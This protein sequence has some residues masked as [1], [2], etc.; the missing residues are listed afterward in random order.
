MF[1]E[2]LYASKDTGAIDTKAG[3]L[4]DW[5]E[6]RL[7]VYGKGRKE[8]WVA[9]SPSTAK[10]V[11]DYVQRERPESYYEELFL[12][13]SGE[14]LRVDSLE[15]LIDRR[16]RAAGIRHVSVHAMR[17]SFALSWCKNGGPL[18]ALQTILG[19]STPTMSLRYGRASSDVA[20]ELHR[21]Y[22]PI[23]RLNMRLRDGEKGS[24]KRPK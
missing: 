15:A 5:Q 8:R 7:K 4:D 6:K 9:L 16:A 24:K 17:H 22:S 13:K 12:N 20:M 21:Q 2:K 23:D 14:P 1:L 3:W 10:S 18:S 11:W 19:H